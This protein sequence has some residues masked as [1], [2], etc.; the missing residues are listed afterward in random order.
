MGNLL[1]VPGWMFKK[2][3]EK[4]NSREAGENNEKIYHSIYRDKLDPG[5]VF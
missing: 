5:P 3:H 1:S 2:N 4:W